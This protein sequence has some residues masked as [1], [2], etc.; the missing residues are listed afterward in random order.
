MGRWVSRLVLLGLTGTVVAAYGCSSSGETNA[1]GSGGS[2]ASANA[3]GSPNAGG[4]NTFDGSGAGTNGGG[5]NLGGGGQGGNATGGGGGGSSMCVDTL[6]ANRDRLLKTYFHYLKANATQ[7]QS[8]GLSSS[9]VNSVC[10]VWTKLDPSSQS[11]YL[12]ITARLQRSI[13]GVDGSSML[14]HVNQLYRLTGGQDATQTDPGSCGGGEYNRMIMSQ[15]AELHTSQL[16]A[17]QHQ[18]AMQGNGKYDIADSPPGGTFWRDSHD[19]GGP[20]GPFDLS[21]ETDTGAPRGQTQ[22]F[23]D[24]SSALANAPL[25]RQDLT[26]LVD[27]YALEM[28][29]DYDC[30]HNSNPI[31]SYTF[32]GAACFPESSELGTQIYTDSYGDFEANWKPS[33]CN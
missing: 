30:A 32:Y 23:Q 26:T 12:T 2:S 24:P 3:G 1:Q 11:V 13:L 4:T 31:C 29:E 14:C 18:G 8:N 33:G 9:N 17:N 21:D 20:H 27:P 28:D 7:P 25:G 10:D 5:S 15:D 6:D 19:A 16:A 22:Y